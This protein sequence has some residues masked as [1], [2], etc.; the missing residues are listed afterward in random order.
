MARRN[1]MDKFYQKA[2]TLAYE[3]AVALN[4][5]ARLLFDSGHLP[6]SVALAISSMEEQVKAYTLLLVAMG[7]LRPESLSWQEGNRV[8]YLLRDHELKDL[9]FGATLRSKFLFA[10][11]IEMLKAGKVPEGTDDLYR[12][13]HGTEEMDKAFKKMD[14]TRQSAIYVGVG[15]EE[16]IEVPSEVFNREKAETY[17]G[18]S[19]ELLPLW[20]EV[21]KNP[22]YWLPILVELAVNQGNQHLSPKGETSN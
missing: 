3:N 9:L 2:A 12:S 21:F 1:K 7:K 8:R 18:W 17:L 13:L 10:E 5:E 15:R 22:T 14:K 4:K 20:G 11:L 19:T 16:P 6:R